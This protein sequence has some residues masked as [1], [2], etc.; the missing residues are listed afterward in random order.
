VDISLIHDPGRMIVALH[1]VPSNIGAMVSAVNEILIHLLDP[2]SQ[3]P[4]V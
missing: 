1:D 2:T 3:G 4:L